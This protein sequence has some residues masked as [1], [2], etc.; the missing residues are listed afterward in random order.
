MT[1]VGFADNV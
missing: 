1:S